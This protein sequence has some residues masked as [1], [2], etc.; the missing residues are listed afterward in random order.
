MMLKPL[1]VAVLDMYD[2]L[3]NEG[4][5]CIK[6]IVHEFA[7]NNNRD[8]QMEVYD[9]RGKNEMADLGFDIYISSGGP[10]SPLDSEG[11][12]WERKF[13]RLMD[14]IQAFNLKHPERRKHVFL[15]CHSFQIYCRYYQ[16]GNVCLRKSTAF[17]IFPT[18][19]TEAGKKELLFEH[20]ND[21]FYVVDSRD[22]QVIEINKNRLRELGGTVLCLEKERPHV[23]LEQAV[24]A[25]R[26]NDCFVG[27][28]FHP[29]SDVEGMLRYLMREDKKNFIISHHSI[30]KYNETLDILHRPE[31]II[32]THNTIL[33]AFLRMATEHHQ[34]YS[35]RA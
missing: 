31:A 9:V 15:I 22:W 26:F 14:D 21:P 32:H 2:G 7:L 6:S 33:P 1:N 12:E 18:H 28:Q 10:G 35:K 19:K 3:P 13:F 5:R 4:M 8:L 23:N 24:M 27:T 29:E 16:L 30:E 25:I 11:S 34:P 17:G 20:L